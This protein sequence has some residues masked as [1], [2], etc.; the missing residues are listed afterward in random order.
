MAMFCSPGPCQDFGR[1]VCSGL[2][3]S[4]KVTI[5]FLIINNHQLDPGIQPLSI[6]FNYQV[7]YYQPL[8]TLK[9]MII[10]GIQLST[11]IN[12]QPTV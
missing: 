5:I 12:Y 7:D 10:D 1:R 8:S 9:L 2:E 3:S 11:T 4:D 6:I